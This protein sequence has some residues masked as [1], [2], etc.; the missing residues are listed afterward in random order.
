M[1]ELQHFLPAVALPM[2]VLSRLCSSN[3]QSSS[4]EPG[5]LLVVLA[6]YSGVVLGMFFVSQEDRP[7]MHPRISYWPYA[8]LD[9]GVPYIAFSDTVDDPI[10]TAYA[11]RSGTKTE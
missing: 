9:V 2:Y 6:T 10:A 5:H 11:E 4:W 3:A 8:S 1:E 7:E